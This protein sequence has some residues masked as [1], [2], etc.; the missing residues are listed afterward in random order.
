MFVKTVVNIQIKFVLIAK[1][2]MNNVKNANLMLNYKFGF[3]YN[4]TKFLILNE[5]LLHFK[6]VLLIVNLVFYN[7]SIKRK[8]T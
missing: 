8:I 4:V 7:N 2:L 6:N 5:F 3:V 1:L